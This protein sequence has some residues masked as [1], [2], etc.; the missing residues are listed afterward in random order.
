MKAPLGF[1]ILIEMMPEPE[2]PRSESAGPRELQEIHPELV[3]ADDRPHA[4]LDGSYPVRDVLDFLLNI[5]LKVIPPLSAILPF[6]NAVRLIALN[7]VVE[8][9]GDPL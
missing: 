1:R 7:V 5:L 4:F 6:F 8:L 2:N 9:L 3:K